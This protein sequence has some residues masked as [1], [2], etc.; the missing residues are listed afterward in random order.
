ME[1][2]DPSCVLA[3]YAIEVSI[4]GSLSQLPPAG[5]FYREL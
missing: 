2:F 5:D 4:R 3:R 1:A